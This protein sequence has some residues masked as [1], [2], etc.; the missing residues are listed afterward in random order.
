MLILRFFHQ[1]LNFMNFFLQLRSDVPLH[2]W[3][4]ERNKPIELF[5]WDRKKLGNGSQEAY[6]ECLIID[7]G[8]FQIGE[9]DG[10]LRALVFHF[11]FIE[12]FDNAL[13]LAFGWFR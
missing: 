8:L 9:I 6:I 7:F 1:L 3:S 2:I 12:V 4:F 10:R 11:L 5:L 13:D